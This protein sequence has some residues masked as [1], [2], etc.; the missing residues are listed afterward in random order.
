LKLNE[1]RKMYIKLAAKCGADK[2]FDTLDLKFPLH[3][4]DPLNGYDDTRVEFLDLK[5]HKQFY[6][7]NRGL[8]KYKAVV[9]LIK[10]DVLLDIER[11]RLEAIEDEILMHRDDAAAMMGIL[12]QNIRPKV[13]DEQV[14]PEQLLINKGRRYPEIYQ[15]DDLVTEDDIETDSNLL[16]KCLQDAEYYFNKE[17]LVEVLANCLVN[18]IPLKETILKFFKPTFTKDQA[19]EHPKAVHELQFRFVNPFDQASEYPL[20]ESFRADLLHPMV[21]PERAV[22]KYFGDKTAIY[23]SFISMYRYQILFPMILGF[24]IWLLKKIDEWTRPKV[25]LDAVENPVTRLTLAVAVLYFAFGVYLIIWTSRLVTNWEKYQVEYGYKYG[26][27]DLQT[28]KTIRNKFEGVYERSLI[29]DEMNERQPDRKRQNFR[30]AIT[31]IILALLTAGAIIACFFLLSLKRF[32]YLRKDLE[33]FANIPV[34]DF[35]YIIFDVSECCRI[36][37]FERLFS[38]IIIWLVKWQDYKYKEDHESQLILCLGLFQ[39]FNNSINIILIGLQ[40]LFEEVVLDSAGKKIGVVS[41]CMETN[42]SNEIQVYFTIY[43]IFRV[44]WVLGIKVIFYNLNKVFLLTLNQV[45]SLPN[46]FTKKTTK[47]ETKVV[48]EQ[49]ATE[50]ESHALNLFYN[51]PHKMYETANLEISKQMQLKEN[52]S[53]EDFD[54]SMMDFLSIFSLHSSVALFGVVFPLGFAAIYAIVFVE[55]WTDSKFLIVGSRRPMAM[56]ANSI[57]LWLDMMKLTSVIGVITNSFYLAFVQ[58]YD[59][60]FD[61]D[62]FL[63]K[64][65]AFLALVMCLYAINF[66]YYMNNK[67]A[68][69]IIQ[70]LKS[71]KATVTARII[72]E[73][74]SVKQTVEGKKT[75]LKTDFHV[76]GKPQKKT[77]ERSAFEIADELKKREGFL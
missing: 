48:H 53:N 73:G 64:F 47:V 69:S 67:K 21:W 75:Y 35:R 19:K 36:Y 62:R 4:R 23:F 65:G 55:F 57:G 42:C 9:Q 24:S 30:F 61:N 49:K 3:Y 63:L 43:T 5:K 34:L 37:I 76:F 74:T 26:Q 31:T 12:Q 27:E 45:V 32:I 22:R 70:D 8:R 28:T 50:Q 66:F 54:A 10:P 39:L 20:T 38:I 59:I 13:E 6:V 15:Y 29:N 33:R 60:N 2:L 1:V 77:K 68:S 44:T 18:S 52:R 40:L 72:R 71:R 25:S 41:H 46:M 16:T 11:K 56:S 51:A 17:R 58:L 14:N 7:E